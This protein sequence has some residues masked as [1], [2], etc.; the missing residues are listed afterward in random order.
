V[1]LVLLTEYLKKRLK[2]D[3]WGNYLFWITFCM[4]GQPVSV[5]TYYHDWVVLHR[6][7]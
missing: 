1:P 2:S 7:A 3:T 6:G 4:V 5:L